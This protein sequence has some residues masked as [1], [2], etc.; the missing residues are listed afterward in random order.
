[1]KN[2]DIVCNKEILNKNILFQGS[3]INK[4][5]YYIKEYISYLSQNSSKIF[6]LDSFWSQKKY[7]RYKSSRY[8]KEIERRYHIKLSVDDFME[9]QNIFEYMNDKEI[10]IMKVKSVMGYM[11]AAELF[12]VIISKVNDDLLE[13]SVYIFINDFILKSLSE[14]EFLDLYMKINKDKIKFF[15]MNCELP[16]PEGLKRIID[17]VIKIN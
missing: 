6:L 11:S 2:Y 17:E 5:K 14:G 10:N 13:N 8:I 12:P 7:S 4:L 16:L 3:D 1:M 15:V 9:K